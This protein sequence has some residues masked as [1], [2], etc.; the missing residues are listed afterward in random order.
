MPYISRRGE[1]KAFV[2]IFERR[3]ICAKTPPPYFLLFD[4]LVMV[5]SRPAPLPLE[6]VGDRTKRAAPNPRGLPFAL[7]WSGLAHERR[8]MGGNV[9]SFL[10]VYSP[11]Y[12]FVFCFICTKLW[13]K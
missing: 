9:V 12:F 11:H 4:A 8:A 10:S 1:E 3:L 7:V 2:V 13:G 5:Q 6:V